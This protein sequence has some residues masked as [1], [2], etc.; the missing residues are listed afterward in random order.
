MIEGMP[1]SFFNK[2]RAKRFVD[3]YNSELGYKGYKLEKTK[4]YNSLLEE[5]KTSYKIVKSN[6]SVK[7]RE[8]KR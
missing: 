5:Y 3:F 2:E 4:K 8:Y 6:K 7:V 1:N